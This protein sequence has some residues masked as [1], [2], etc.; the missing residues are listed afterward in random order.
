VAHDFNNFL[1]VING[2]G[3]ML[4]EGLDG[5]P[6]LQQKADQIRKAGSAAAAI[7]D[8]LLAFSQQRA[9]QPEI[10]DLNKTVHDCRD[11]LKQLLGD[12]SALELDLASDLHPVMATL[13][14]IQQ[15]LVNLTVNARDAM[16]GRGRL[17]IRT[18]NAS[19]PGHGG[20]YVR[21]TVED[22][23]A[24]IPPEVLPKIFEPFFTTKP[25][26]EGTG[27]GLAT[28]Y[29]IVKQ[30]EGWVDVESAPGR[31]ATFHVYLPA[32]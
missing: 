18:A 27:L 32:A 20:R 15:V 22:S 23:G 28:V 13:T 29:G 31:G 21:I 1:T 24:G 9:M 7:T 6:E 19:R 11:I 10:V 12:G 30:R 4:V 14:G 25:V 3:N 16:P 17:V 26:G 8:Q 5:Q 2:Y